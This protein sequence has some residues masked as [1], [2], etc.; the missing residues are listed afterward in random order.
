VPDLVKPSGLAG[1]GE[2]LVRLG[3]DYIH[4]NLFIPSLWIYIH[5]V[6]H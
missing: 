2:N 1:S 4:S 5:I 6:E 3:S